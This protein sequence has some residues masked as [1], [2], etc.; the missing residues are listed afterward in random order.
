MAAE[1]ERQ[2]RIEGY[3]ERPHDELAIIIAGLEQR[4]RFQQQQVNELTVKRDEMTEA[5]GSFESDQ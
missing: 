5:F 1:A 3:R 4:I 2:A